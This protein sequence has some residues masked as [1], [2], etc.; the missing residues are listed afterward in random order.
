MTGMMM[1][2]AVG[3]MVLTVI[4]NRYWRRQLKLTRIAMSKLKDKVDDVTKEVA[5]VA[6]DYAKLSHHQAEME[7]RVQKAEIDLQAAIVDLDKKKVAPMNR[8][9]VFDRQEP[10]PGRFWEVA[11]RH[12]AVGTS[13]GD[14]YRGWAGIRRYLLIGDGERDVRERVTGRFPRKAGFEVVEAAGCRIS[15]LSVNRISELSTFRKPV[16]DEDGA[17]AA[18]PARKASPARS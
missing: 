7:K 11:V 15:G 3:L 12:S 17:A 1:Y 10:R 9:F 18:K 2:I 4:S 13:Y 6:S 14:S 16:K 5:D 8:Y